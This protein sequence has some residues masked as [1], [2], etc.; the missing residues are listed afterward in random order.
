MRHL[1]AELRVPG[2]FLIV[3]PLSTMQHWRREIESFTDDLYAVIYHGSSEDRKLIRQTE[4]DVFDRKGNH[5]QGATRF[6]VL[7]TSFDTAQ[8]DVSI[9]SKIPWLCLVVDEAHRMK[10]PKSVL[11]TQLLR[12]RC[13]H[14]LLMTGTPI[15]NNMSELWSLLNFLDPNRFNSLDA[16]VARHAVLETPEQVA[17]LSADINQYIL[18]RLKSDVNLKLMPKEEIIVEV[19]LTHLQKRYYKAIFEQNLSLLKQFGKKG[20]Q[21]SLRNVSMQ[22][23]KCCYHPYL[24]DGVEDELLGELQQTKQQ[25][26]DDDVQQQLIMASGKMVLLD[27]LLAKLFQNGHK[28][29][30]FSQMTRVL[31]LIQDYCVHRRYQFERLDGQV[32]GNS[33][34][35][36][37]DRFS[38]S[39]NSFIFL[40]S[41]KAGGVGL[42]LT[43][44]DTV[45]LFDCDWN[46]QVCL[47]IL[48]YMLLVFCLH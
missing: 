24:L 16:F 5:V 41:T 27:K 8:M 15:Q 45:I 31:D 44:A 4:F 14:V 22:L 7:I 1:Y 30:I 26:D 19:E 10:S 20:S 18:R 34:Q 43:A 13:E 6:Q 38:T 9:L 36:A 33:R 25:I 28:V 32:L 29:L 12:L 40:I 37:I 42:T 23:R 17:A 2:P 35:E 11:R 48:L 47:N 46:P 39:A 3:A 21:I